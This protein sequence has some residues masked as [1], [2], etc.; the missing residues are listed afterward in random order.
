[1]AAKPIRQQPDKSF[2]LPKIVPTNTWDYFFIDTPMKWHIGCSG[3]YYKSW[4][5]KFYPE[6]LPQRLWLQYYAEHFNTVEVNATFYHFP[7]LTFLKALYD[8]SPAKFV[9]TIKAPRL[10][11][12]YKKFNE[13]KSLVEDFYNV[14]D[15]GMGKKLGCVLFQLPRNI[16]Y[17][18]E[19]LH[20][21][22]DNLYPDFLNVIEF[23]HRSWWKESVYKH[24]GK[25]KICFCSISHPTLP[26]TLIANTSFIYYRLHGSVR[27]YHSLYKTETLR[28]LADNIK[29]LKK[30]KQAFIYFN[31]DVNAAATKNAKTIMELA[32]K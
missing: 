8:K 29:E 6:K 16:V 12:H 30:V 15:K 19:K 13:T 26:H 18:E 9:F 5:N 10:I 2:E 32:K 25:K 27:L 11:T 31:N 24:L 1:M 3:F 22:T 17:S 7:K 20:Q 14:L 28:R 4:R 23:R 21:I